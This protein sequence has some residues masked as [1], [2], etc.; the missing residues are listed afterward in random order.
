YRTVTYYVAPFVTDGFTDGLSF[1]Y[2]GQNG[3]GLSS[4]LGNVDLEPEVNTTYEAG[5]E[6]KLFGNRISLDL[7]Y[8]QSTSS[9]LLVNRPI[10]SSTGFETVFQNFGEM[11]NKGWEIEL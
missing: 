8:Y 2:N 5:V 4:A 10:A 6:L 1:P 7:N 3:F 11:V 9:N